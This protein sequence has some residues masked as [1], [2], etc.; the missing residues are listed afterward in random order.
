MNGA[1]IFL[2][3]MSVIMIILLI[4][5]YIFKRRQNPQK[6][7][8]RK[9]RK[10]RKK[11]KRRKRRRSITVGGSPRDSLD[12]EGIFGHLPDHYSAQDDDNSESEIPAT[13]TTTEVETINE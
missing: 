4:V 8:K 1:E 2:I 11:S 6:R 9:R 5:G 10:R 3:V 13:Y 12:Q 7:E